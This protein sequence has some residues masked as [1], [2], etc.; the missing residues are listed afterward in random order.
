MRTLWYIPTRPTIMQGDSE[1]AQIVDQIRKEDPRFDKR[2]YFFLRHGLDHT[3]RQIKRHQAERMDK[4]SHVSGGELLEGLR[5]FA[6]DQFGPMAKLVLNEW[7]VTRCTD[8]GDMVYN[9]IEYQVFSKTEADRREDFSEKYDFE[10]AFVKPFQAARRHPPK[11]SHGAP[12][13]A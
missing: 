12:E 3:V 9:L 1:F 7:G 4:S 2:A 5:E 13:L 10:D 11:G 6:L 8:F